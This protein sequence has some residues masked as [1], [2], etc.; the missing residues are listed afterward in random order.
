[1][2][3][4]QYFVY[5]SSNFQNTVLYTGVTN[6]LIRRTWE[7]K[8]KLVS[9]FASRYN[10]VKLVYVEVFDDVNL[11]IAREKQIK[12]GSREKKILL[13]RTLNPNYDDLY[14]KII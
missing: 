2:Q 14:L 12:A 10:I 4:R 8:Q 13:I 5:I 7:H 6:N 9:S 1:M 3:T 11:A